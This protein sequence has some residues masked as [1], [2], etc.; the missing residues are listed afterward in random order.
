M[1]T[2]TL[3]TPAALWFVRHGE[4][5]ANVAREAAFARDAEEVDMDVRDMD[6]PLSPLGERQ[7]TALGQWFAHRPAAERPT[8]VIASPYQ[9]AR[10]TA[11]RIVAAGGTADGP[12][13]DDERADDRLLLDE[14]FREKEL[15]LY[16]RITYRGVQRRFPE[17][18]ALRQE[19]GLFYYRPPN[20]ESGA[21]VAFRVRAGLD[22]VAREHAGERVLVVCHQVTILCGRYVLERMTEDE[23]HRAW[24][25]YDLANCS[26]TEYRPDAAH[27]GRLALRQLGF[28]V[29]VLSEGVPV[30][31]EPHPTGGAPVG[32]A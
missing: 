22:A 8:V 25:A 23:L 14:R 3:P 7:A 12:L 16:Y 27:G 31:S 21:D 9:R 17:Q 20:G 29:P 19:L 28:T 11:A 6:V 32:P 13:G 5:A 30:T 10:E 26:V 2:A 4:S 24:R 18:W 15:G 1:P